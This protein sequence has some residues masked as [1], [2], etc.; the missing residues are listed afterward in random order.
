[1]QGMTHFEIYAKGRLTSIELAVA[2]FD[3]HLK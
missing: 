3:E 1:M 2:W